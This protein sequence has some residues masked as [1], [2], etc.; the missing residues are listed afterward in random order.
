MHE[1]CIC[2]RP[3]AEE[4]PANV[5]FV[6]HDGTQ[7]KICAECRRYVHLL[8]VGG[9]PND[10]NA[11]VNYIY[12]C[13]KRKNDPDVVAYFKDVFESNKTVIKNWENK[14][15]WVG[16][17]TE[18]TPRAR[19][20]GWILFMEIFAWISGIG[21]IV[22]GIA[23]SMQVG[24]TIIKVSGILAS[25]IG[26]LASIVSIMIFLNLAEDVSEIK[27]ILKNNRKK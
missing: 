2:G 25:I 21:L 3:L 15:E 5:L 26:G 17:I 11:A 18:Y 7:K 9:S 8:D 16:V 23:L 27:S 12:D 13:V 10:L 22:G 24:D 4:A 19:G 20:M 14:D 1:C 6:K